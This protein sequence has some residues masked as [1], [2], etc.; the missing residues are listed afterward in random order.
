MTH[1]I[2]EQ[3]F[4]ELNFFILRTKTSANSKKKIKEQ[5]KLKNEEHSRSTVIYQ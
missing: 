2:N 5:L 4:M 3:K 1:L